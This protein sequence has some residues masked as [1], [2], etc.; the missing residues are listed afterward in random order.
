[1]PA[2]KKAPHTTR[3]EGVSV[4]LDPKLHYLAGIAAR[5]QMRTLSSFI[6]WAVRRTLSDAA[7]MNDEPTPGLI[8]ASPRRLWHEDL[9]DSDEA[10]RFFELATQRGDLLEVSESRLWNL[11]LMHKK[12]APLSKEGF[13][14]F[15][16]GSIAPPEKKGGK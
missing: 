15:W 1:M 16:E 6:E 12:K 11:Y 10:G 13:R 2:H 14:L 3:S 7:A 4:R 8:P 5:E 9:W